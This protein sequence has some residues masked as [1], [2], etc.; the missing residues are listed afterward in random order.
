MLFPTTRRASRRGRGGVLDLPLGVGRFHALQP[1]FW[2]VFS[3]IP[4]QLTKAVVG[5]GS[6]VDPFSPLPIHLCALCDLCGSPPHPDPQTFSDGLYFEPVRKGT[7]L[8]APPPGNGCRSVISLS[9]SGSGSESGSESNP[10]LVGTRP[11]RT[12]QTSLSS[13][14]STAT[15]RLRTRLLM[16]ESHHAFF[17]YRSR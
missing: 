10:V 6:D 12:A 11:S 1:T 2:G 16:F 3:V 7:F 8:S 13:C 5:N 9:E 17:R 4:I 15:I 14:V